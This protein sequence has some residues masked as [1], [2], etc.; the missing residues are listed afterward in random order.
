MTATGS[1]D[2]DSDDGLERVAELTD[3]LLDIEGIATVTSLVTVSES[4]SAARDRLLS[5]D[6]RTTALVV[7]T[8][9]GEAFETRRHD[10]LMDIRAELAADDVQV[11]LGGYGVVF[12]ALNE[13]STTGAVSL[14]LL[15]HLMMA[16]RIVAAAPGVAPRA[17]YAD[18]RQH[19]DV[20]D[21]GALLRNREPAEHGDDGPAYPGAGDRR[22]RIACTSFAASQRRTRTW[23]KASE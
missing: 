15:A 16:A 5:V 9:L 10:L 7:Q 1:L 6:H 2:F 11:H 20:V 12:D 4:L 22:R 14:I 17:G 18:R 19:G 21:D 8:M 23:H 3:R 13:A